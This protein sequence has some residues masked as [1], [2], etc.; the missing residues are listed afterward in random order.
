MTKQR[1]ECYFKIEKGVWHS[2]AYWLWHT[3]VRWMNFWASKSQWTFLG[4]GSRFIGWNCETG[5][6]SC[7]SLAAGQCFSLIGYDVVQRRTVVWILWYEDQMLSSAYPS[8]IFCGQ[9]SYD[10]SSQLQGCGKM[11]RTRFHRSVFRLG[12]LLCCKG[13]YLEIIY[14]GRV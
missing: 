6:T 13:C 14:G 9:R 3:G 8:K 4:Q 12:S 5:N 10:L 7:I 1:A 11:E 2:V